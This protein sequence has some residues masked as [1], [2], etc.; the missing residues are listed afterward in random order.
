MTI[1]RRILVSHL[2]LVALFLLFLG[3][4]GYL[5]LVRAQTDTDLTRLYRVKSAWGDLLTSMSDIVNN[6]EDGRSYL[7]FRARLDA[8]DREVTALRGSRLRSFYPERQRRNIDALDEIWRLA[9]TNTEVINRHIENPDFQRAVRTVSKEPGLQRLNHLWVALF[10]GADETGRKDAYAVRQV[11]DAI[12]FFPIYSDTITRQIDI[13]LAA[14]TKVYGKVIGVQIALSISFFVVFLVAYL[15]FSLLFTRSISRP[16]L[17][18]SARLKGFIGQSFDAA[19]RE[20]TDELELLN[21]SVRTLI[22][23]YTKLSQ[24]AR[25]LSEGDGAR[26]DVDIPERGVI[27]EAFNVMSQEIHEKI[28]TLSRIFDAIDE[29]ILV[30]DKDGEIVESNNRLLKLIDVASVAEMRSAGGLDRFIRG[31]EKTRQTLAA[32]AGHENRSATMITSRNQRV[33]VR[34]TA[35]R[36]DPVEGHKDKV[37]LFITNESW[38]V[39]MRRERERLRSQAVVAELK[40]L[41]A[42]IN[43]HFLF[44]TLN[45]IIQLIETD[46]EHAVGTTEKL[47]DIFRYAMATTERPTVAVSEELTHVRQFLQIEQARFEEN[48][49]VE[50]HVD[51]SVEQERMPPMLLQPIVENALLHGKDSQGR[52][53][54]SLRAER[55]G[56]EVVFEIADSGSST[57]VDGFSNGRGMGLRNVNDR[58]RTL[59]GRTITISRNGSHG[60]VVSMSLPVSRGEGKRQ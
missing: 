24:I 57:S 4:Y 15:A 29:A 43:P 13:I 35:R 58:L 53:F 30:V 42:Q 18:A 37:M 6:W 17:E 48:L 9:L 56:E 52:V 55:R 1:R 3:G 27:G 22:D 47:A 41:R 39:R 28:A 7:A 44:N 26:S 12:E 60:V 8:F 54:L 50:W 31:Y 46:P 2:F 59:Y 32:G 40:A 23:H 36:L 25:R 16:L 14:T 11:L 19:Q 5:G 21:D 33:P 49:Q 20:H 10:Y 51:G 45:T 34:V 38:K